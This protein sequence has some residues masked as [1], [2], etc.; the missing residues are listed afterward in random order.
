MGEMGMEIKA[1]QG[2][3]TNKHDVKKQTSAKRGVLTGIANAYRR[4]QHGK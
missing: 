3:V 2:M 4:W 1:F